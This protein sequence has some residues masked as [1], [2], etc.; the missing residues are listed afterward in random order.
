MNADPTTDRPEVDDPRVLSL[1]K[2]R[3]HIAHSSVFNV[4][5]PPWDGLTAQ[6]QHLSLLDARNY[7]HAALNAGLVPAAA[8]SVAVPPTVDEIAARVA[9]KRAEPSMR[10]LA[11]AWA[12]PARQTGEI[13]GFVVWLDASD[14]SVPTHDGVRWP[15][16]T[17]TVRHRHFRHTT[18]H[19]DPEAARHAAHGKQG[20]IVWPEAAVVLAVA[21]A[22]Q[23]DMRAALLREVA[24]YLERKAS[25][26]TENLHDRPIFVAKARLAEAELLDREAAELRRMADCHECETG[27]EHTVHCP[28]PETH[29][30]GCGC[31]TDVAA[32]I[33]SCPGREMAPSPCRCPCEGC[34]HHCGAHDPDTAAVLPQPE[35][36]AGHDDT[37]Q[38]AKVVRWVTS[39]V[40]SAKTEFGDGYRAAQRDIRDL[41]KGRFDNDARPATVA[42]PDEEA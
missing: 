30:W 25:A 9:A 40:V 29:N 18:T 14:G 10:A 38:L 35:T 42:Q 15:D 36:Q 2:A 37:V 32:A 23:A 17:A 6:E 22:E 13:A 24:A 1:A 34:K 12:P 41:V 27:A 21:D 19:A 11:A 3:Q 8:V 16:G 7:L 26:L 28:T 39:E 31:P 33:A 4:V 5:C 20:R